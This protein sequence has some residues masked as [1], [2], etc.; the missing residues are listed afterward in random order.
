[1]T[2]VGASAE[3]GVLVAENS[4]VYFSGLM[5]VCTESPRRGNVD[6][7][8]AWQKVRVSEELGGLDKTDFGLRDF[9]SPE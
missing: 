6:H 8:P 9:S 4:V 2:G 7:V 3:E 1:M 5:T